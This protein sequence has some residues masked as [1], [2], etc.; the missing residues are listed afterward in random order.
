LGFLGDATGSVI[1]AVLRF[2]PTG[3]LPLVRFNDGRLRHGGGQTLALADL[4][5]YGG[6]AQVFGFGNRVDVFALAN[7]G[8]LGNRLDNVTT[9]ADRGAA[10]TEFE[11]PL[12]TPVPGKRDAGIAT[13]DSTDELFFVQGGL[14]L[15]QLGFFLLEGLVS[16][17]LLGE[18]DGV[19]KI[20]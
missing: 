9:V 16:G 3:L 19:G 14:N 2:R 18:S 15:R 17:L 11:L 6:R 4:A 13:L 8:G 7:D 5:A 1:A 20:P 12:P 10:E